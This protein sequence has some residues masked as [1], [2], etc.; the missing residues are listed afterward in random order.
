MTLVN[1]L[2]NGH[3]IEISFLLLSVLINI[4]KQRILLP[5]Q[6]GFVFPFL[7]LGDDQQ[8]LSSTFV[9]SLLS[10]LSL[11]ENDRDR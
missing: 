2:R 9:A 10:R 11:G 6:V 7:S 1:L 8:D 5:A 3:I 4:I